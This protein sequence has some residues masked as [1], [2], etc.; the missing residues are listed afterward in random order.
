VVSQPSSH[1]NTFIGL[2]GFTPPH[3]LATMITAIT[4]APVGSEVFTAIA[5]L[6]ISLVVVLILRYYLPLRTTP[7]YLLVPV[8]FA[9]WLPACIILLMPIDLASSART[10]DEA[11]RGI[12]LPHRVLL[13]WWR[14]TYWLTFTLTWYAMRL[15]SRV[16]QTSSDA[17]AG[18]YFP[19][20]PNTPTRV[21]AN[22]KTKSST[23]SAR[24][25][26]IT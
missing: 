7:A 15:G 6:A 26:N 21:T 3:K 16:S 24:T 17:L 5:L 25:P 19:S 20:S 9:L 10:D 4:G 23:P 18:S 12:W 11:T 1:S 8:F 14:I 22:P 13:V 2:H